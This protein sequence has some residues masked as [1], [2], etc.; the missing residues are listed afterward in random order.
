ME[1]YWPQR[2]KGE[3]DQWNLAFLIE[4]MFGDDVTLH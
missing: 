1:R 4:H 3:K 2:D